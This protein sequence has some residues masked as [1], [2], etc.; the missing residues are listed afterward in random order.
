[1]SNDGFLVDSDIDEKFFFHLQVSDMVKKIDFLYF[2]IGID[3]ES[4]CSLCEA[5]KYLSGAECV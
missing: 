5:R 4:V 1:M 2:V 3:A